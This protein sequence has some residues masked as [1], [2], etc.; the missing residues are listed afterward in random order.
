M[1]SGRLPRAALRRLVA[2]L[3]DVEMQRQRGGR[4]ALASGPTECLELD[5]LERLGVV[6]I[7]HETFDLPNDAFGE[8]PFDTLDE[9]VD[10]IAARQPSRLVART[11]GSTG[12]PRPCS[13][14]IADLMA[15]AAWFAEQV[16]E[17]QRVVAM[18]PATHLY[19]IV[20]TA[21]LPGLMG[22]P[23][24]EAAIGRLPPLQAH[25]MIVAVPEQ[26]S[27]LLRVCSNW[28]PNVIGVNSAGPLGEG[29]AAAAMDAGLAKM[30]DVYG[31][32]ETGA[33][34]MRH[35]LEDGYALLP[36]WRIGED[37]GEPQLVSRDGR[38]LG[39]PDRIAF[40]DE[41]RFKPT[42]RF[43]GA[44][45]V[46]GLNV[47]PL[48]VATRLKSVPGVEDAA[49]RLGS[50]GRLKAFLVPA[51]GHLPADIE[52]SVRQLAREHFGPAERPSHLSFGPALPKNAMGKLSDWSET[53][54][55]DG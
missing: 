12:R 37:K 4:G 50:N 38:R 2:A 28:P 26:W 51:E 19:G 36:H 25:D 29:I 53:A 6:A 49:V 15:E 55:A 10:A 8:E 52:T 13:H 7:L 54:P 20:W 11:S 34:G 22:V 3:I 39:F 5:S 41:G 43:D 32:T 1:R 18:V 33:I 44:V 9:W 46:G 45:Q 21:L 35:A 47:Y 17:C 23:V 14:D 24:L 31:S 40:L 42:G 16:P 30:I 27:A 48:H